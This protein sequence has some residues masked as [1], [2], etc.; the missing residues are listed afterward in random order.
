MSRTRRLWNGDADANLAENLS[1]FYS[2]RARARGRNREKRVGTT[3]RRWYRQL[4]RSNVWKDETRSAF[5]D[6]SIRGRAIGLGYVI[7]A[8]INRAIND[9]ANKIIFPLVSECEMVSEGSSTMLY[10]TRWYDRLLAFL[11]KARNNNRES[12]NAR[13]SINIFTGFLCTYNP[14]RSRYRRI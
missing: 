8:A 1:F 12:L 14:V 5:V 3:I 2:A 13:T 4:K 9:N 7:I 10:E 11:A 6:K